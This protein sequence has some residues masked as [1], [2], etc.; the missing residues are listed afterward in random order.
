MRGLPRYGTAIDSTHA[1]EQWC[2][3]TD[4]AERHVDFDRGT[5]AM[6]VGFCRPC[7]KPSLWCKHLKQPAASHPLLDGSHVGEDF[8]DPS[9]MVLHVRLCL[10]INH[11]LQYG[12]RNINGEEELGTIAEL[13][14][15]GKLASRLLSP[16][17]KA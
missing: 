4:R 7:E 2:L 8:S 16:L 11:R 1:Q 6:V 12:I 5:F 14:E 13:G 9:N 17:Y 3:S 10:N 15:S